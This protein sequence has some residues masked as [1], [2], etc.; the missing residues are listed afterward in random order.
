M[1]SAQPKHPGP[2]VTAGMLRYGVAGLILLAPL[3]FGSVTPGALL[4][5]TLAICLLAA[6]ALRMPSSEPGWLSPPARAALWVYI[7]LVGIAAL[8]LLPVPSGIAGWLAPEALRLRQLA[9]GWIPMAGRYGS[10]SLA[11]G[12]TLLAGAQL[13]ACGLLG[14]TVLRAAQAERFWRWVGAAIAITGLFQAAYGSIELLSGRQEILGYAKVHYLDSATG[15]LI[16]RNHY[17]SLLAM[18]L[19]FAWALP[20]ALAEAHGNSRLRLRYLGHFDVQ[21]GWLVVG[22][23]ASSL[24]GLGL[25]LSRSRAGLAA[26]AVATIVLATRAQRQRGWL[27]GIAI[28]I[29]VSLLTVSV[30][31]TRHPGDRL[32]TLSLDLA[33]GADRPQVW[34]AT[35]LA[36]TTYGPLGAGLGTYAGAFGRLQPPGVEGAYSHAHSDWLQ[37]LF[38]GGPL[39]LLA[40]TAFLVFVI[41]GRSV[42]STSLAIGSLRDGALAAILAFAAHCLVDFPARIPAIAALASVCAALCLS[43]GPRPDDEV[44]KSRKHA[45]RGQVVLGPVPA[46]AP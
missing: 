27:L 20:R 42:E 8:Q 44:L 14:F 5:L 40:A 43:S 39:S 19:P 25:L 3:R 18:C 32:G 15:T 6:L 24:I 38:E 37:L 29:L 23:A 33:R 34:S 26:A 31:D 22:V 10:V 4:A 30:L 21:R 13:I 9:A 45:P 46:R 2:S 1:R 36:T 7:A 16:N 28:A 17:A 12:E 11:P 41:R 35:L